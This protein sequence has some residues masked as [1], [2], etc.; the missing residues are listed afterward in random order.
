MTPFGPG[1]GNAVETFAG[2]TFNVGTYAT[3]FTG[4][5]ATYIALE[6]GQTYELK[7]HQGETT[8]TY[9]ATEDKVTEIH[10]DTFGFMAHQGSNAIAVEKGTVVDSGSATFLVKSGASNETLTASFYTKGRKGE[11][12]VSG[13]LQTS[14]SPKEQDF[15]V[16]LL[17]SLQEPLDTLQLTGKPSADFNIQPLA[18]GI[19]SVAISVDNASDFKSDTIRFKL[20][21]NQVSQLDTITL[22]DEIPPRIQ[23]I[24]DSDTLDISDTLRFIVFD[25]GGPLSSSKINI[26]YENRNL[27][28]FTL[29][30]D[31][32]YVPFN[33]EASAQNWTTKFI[34]VSVTDPSLNTA[35][36][37]F[38]LRPNSTLP[39]V[40]SE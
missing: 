8:A 12:A 35:K 40:F 13:I 39:E 28:D 6:A 19:Y 33:K 26:S 16:I 2:A 1:I 20:E 32:L 27:Q 24:S 7:N 31:T 37:I 11:G 9:T 18:K 15:K 38:Y 29:S 25:Q 14:S 21:A 23:S 10:S 30:K 17:D 4:G 22:V 36:H 3:I 34:T 5:S